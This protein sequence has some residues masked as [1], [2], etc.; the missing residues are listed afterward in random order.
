MRGVDGWHPHDAPTNRHGL[1]D[2]QRMNPAYELV[3]H[4]PT[5]HR[6]PLEVAVNRGGDLDGGAVMG[7]EDDA[8]HARRSTFLRQIPAV[9]PPGEE[10]RRSVD[11]HVPGADQQFVGAHSASNQSAIRPASRL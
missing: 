10:A 4:N 7:L 11:V 2:D 6:E 8:P 1:L 3:E 5:Q 9:S